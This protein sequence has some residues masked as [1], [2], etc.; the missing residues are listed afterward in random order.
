MTALLYVGLYFLEIGVFGLL[1]LTREDEDQLGF[2][3]IPH[4]FRL[5]ILVIWNAYSHQKSQIMATTM[6]DTIPLNIQ[7]RLM[8]R[9]P[10]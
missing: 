9:H 1:I 10:C 5:L 8:P 2:A 7:P 4:I 3:F 6:I